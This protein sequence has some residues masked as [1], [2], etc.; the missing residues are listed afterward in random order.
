MRSRSSFPTIKRL[1]A[2]DGPG[3]IGGRQDTVDKIRKAL[4]DGGVTFTNGA[5]PG[6][7]LKR[8]GP[9]N[10]GTNVCDLTSDNDG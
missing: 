7:K 2:D 4:E 6:V 1:E 9:A 8:T 5:E 3:Q 10:Q